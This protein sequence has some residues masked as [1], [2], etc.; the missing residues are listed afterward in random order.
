MDYYLQLALGERIWA[1]NNLLAVNLNSFEELKSIECPGKADGE[2][3]GSGRRRI[4]SPESTEM[5][6]SGCRICSSS[7][8]VLLLT[9]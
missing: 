5:S 3:E 1:V 6:R 9:R 4:G 8:G 7:I 2:S